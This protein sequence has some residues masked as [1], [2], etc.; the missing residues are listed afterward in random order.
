MHIAQVSPLFE[1]VPPKAYGGTERVVSW[2]TEELVHQGHTVTLF[3]S[4]DSQTRAR[5][6]KGSSKA[7]WQDPSS[8]E[9]LP[10]HLRELEMVFSRRN[11]FDIV[12]FHTDFIHFPLLRRDPLPSLTT[13]H[14]A[15]NQT[16]HAPLF[17]E[18]P[19]VPLI[20]ISDAQ[21]RGVPGARFERTIHHGMPLD[22]HR[23][24]AQGGDYLAFVGRASP[25]KGLDRAI[26]I[27]MGSGRKLKIAARICPEERAYYN[28]VIAPLLDRA[29]PLAEF[30]GEVGGQDKDDFLRGAH[31]L[32][33][34]IDWSEPFGLVMIEALATGTP[35]VA[36]RNGSVPEVIEH[37][38]TGFVVE[39]IDEAI[40]AVSRVRDLDRAQCRRSFERRFSVQRMTERYLETYQRQLERQSRPRLVASSVRGSARA[41][42]A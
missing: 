11:E 3:A 2:L 37:G 17:D 41:L 1:S 27:A 34:P 23:Y 36:W 33:F 28:D 24:S 26:R 30:I 25:Q 10:L 9:S 14:G 15:L 20:S 6:V 12:H 38:T 35:V 7:L 39:S 29:G 21:R 22:L 40:A 5:L 4:G 16:D 18:Y 19:E 31:A 8:L 42:R 13:L 32:L